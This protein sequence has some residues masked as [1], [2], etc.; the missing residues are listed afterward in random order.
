M[1]KLYRSITNKKIAGICGGIGE[2]MDVDPTIIRLVLVIITIMTGIIPMLV[3]YIL[4]WWIIPEKPGSTGASTP[5][6]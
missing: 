2:Q 1:T 4:A 6:A 3:G 5:A